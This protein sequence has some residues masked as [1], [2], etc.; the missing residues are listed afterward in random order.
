M[1]DRPGVRV[2]CV[3]RVAGH[4]RDGEAFGD[5]HPQVV[6]PGEGRHELGVEGGNIP[7]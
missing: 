7:S 4:V 6:G 3:P 5:V 2:L 1:D